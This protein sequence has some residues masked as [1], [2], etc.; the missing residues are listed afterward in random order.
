MRRRAPD[1]PSDRSAA[2]AITPAAIRVEN[3]TFRYHGQA[4]PAVDGVGFSVA[5]GEIFGLL[6]PSGAGKSTLQKVLTRQQRRFEGAVEV[7]GKPL[8]SWGQDY[9]EAIGVG[10]ELPNHYVK[11]T[12]VENLR[13][14]ASLYKRK[15]RDPLELLALVGLADAANKKVET[16]SKGMRMRL[17]F[18]RAIQHDPE[19]LFLDEPTA[20][21][22]PINAGIIKR[23][24]ADLRRAG[25]TVVLTTHNMNDVDELCDRVSFMVT[26]RFAA[27]DAP[28]AL[29]AKYGRRTVR[30]TH[31]RDVAE[32]D[33]F[34]LDGLA[35]DARFLA[36]LR[37][38]AVRTL[39][40]QEA[41]LDQVFSDVTGTS[42]DH[43]EEAA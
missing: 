33:E 11:F 14:F 42:L 1:L 18:V 19:I 26:G 20:G 40:S 28:E 3:L 31:G 25:K 6:G 23:L 16:F 29:K 9:F 8:P 36:I 39:H 12:A 5:H 10:F 35:D 41:S 27:L 15:S 43:V 7:L 30:I 4:K 13:F 2:P 17:N 37:A 21:L 38:G 24:I 22:D 34:P 32:T